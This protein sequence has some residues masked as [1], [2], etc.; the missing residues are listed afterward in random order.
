VPSS[1]A[2]ERGL[3][4]DLDDTLVPWNTL[5]HWQWAW[6][7]QGPRLPQR[8]VRSALRRALRA[9]DRR[10]W[11]GLVGPEAPPEE[12]DRR[13][14]LEECLRGIAGHRL[15][16]AETQAVLARFDK[17]AGEIETYD[18]AGPALR[19]LETDG[20]AVGVVTH[21]PE[22]VARYALRRVGLAAV[23]LLRHAGDPAAERIPAKAGFRAALS[24]LGVP[25][26]RTVFAGDLFWS[27]VRA[28]ARVGMTAVLLDRD[29][30]FGGVEA[31]RVASLLELVTVL[32]TNEPPPPELP[33]EGPAPEEPGPPP[34]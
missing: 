3:L 15:P 23:P 22:P 11:H 27:D 33:N 12:A 29:D 6:R 32:P 16:D 8:H 7:P 14:F 21:L 31:R 4:L 24:T 19:R 18:D 26:S 17:P 10:R 9:W 34:A 13:A 5:S 20:V 28:A 25:A 30:R 2:P 1:S